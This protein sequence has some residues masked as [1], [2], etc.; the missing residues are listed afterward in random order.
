MNEYDGI[1]IA[2]AW[3]KYVGKQTG[4]WY[5]LPMRWLGF[6]KNFHYQ[7]GHAALVLVDK[8]TGNCKYFDCGRFHAPYQFGRIRGESTDTDLAIRTVAD[9]N[10]TSIGNL[11]NI[12]QEIQSNPS[13]QGQGPLYAAYCEVNTD[14]VLSSVKKTQNK[15]VIP[16]GPFV[17]NGTNCCR[18]VRAGVLAGNP[19][20]VFKWPLQYLWYLR[21]MPITLYHFLSNKMVVEAKRTDYRQG[22]NVGPASLYNK[23]NVHGTLPAPTL[24]YHLPKES[25]W[26]GGEVVGSWFFLEKVGNDY[27]IKRF[28][29]DGHLE[30]EGVFE[31]K[32]NDRFDLTKPY[33]LTYLSHCTMVTIEQNNSTYQFFKK[34]DHAQ[35]HI[36]SD[37]AETVLHT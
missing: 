33:R 36:Q 11:K 13:F 6:N 12:L 32:N 31:L 7:V 4:S 24:P 10:G 29:W 21:P 1:A 9:W 17:M 34:L 23:K 22:K 30:C 8:R 35:K 37:T 25:K 20:G 15:G 14:F 16:F 19:A 2:L 26:L 18:F 28:S 5:D 3:P 27:S